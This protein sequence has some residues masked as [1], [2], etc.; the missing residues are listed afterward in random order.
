MIVKCPHCGK[1]V[2]VNGLGR[3]QLDIPLKNV[4]EALQAHRDVTGGG[5][6]TWL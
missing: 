6:G 5:A 1:T 4:S 2:P 3:K